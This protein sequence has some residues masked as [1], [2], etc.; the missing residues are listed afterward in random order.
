VSKAPWARHCSSDQP[1]VAVKAND[2]KWLVAMVLEVLPRSFVLDSVAPTRGEMLI[3]TGS[4]HTGEVGSVWRYRARAKRGPKH[5]RF[6]RAG[7][8]VL[9]SARWGIGIP[10][11]AMF[12]A[13][14]APDWRP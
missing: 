4:T 13:A 1:D 6:P 12:D 10:Q 11:S 8:A 7:S 14:T 9:Q 2:H 5:G 3:C